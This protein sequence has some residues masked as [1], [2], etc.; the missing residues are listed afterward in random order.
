MLEDDK[1]LEEQWE[2]YTQNLSCMLVCVCMCT[3]VC[4]AGQGGYLVLQPLGTED[5]RSR[6]SFEQRVKKFACFSVER[7]QHACADH[8]DEDRQELELVNLAH[9]VCVH[10]A[11][12]PSCMHPRT[13]V[14]ACVRACMHCVCV[15]FAL[16]HVTWFGETQRTCSRLARNADA[17]RGTSLMLSSRLNEAH[18][19]S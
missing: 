3:C 13:R 19:H 7:M 16:S 11:H 9:H 4:R 8:I 17:S 10:H 12:A 2:R 5:L 14:R 15:F 18:S 6:H 1:E